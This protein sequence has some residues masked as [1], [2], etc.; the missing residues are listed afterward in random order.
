MVAVSSGSREIVAATAVA[1]IM[2]I[3]LSCGAVYGL[4]RYLGPIEE[5]LQTTGSVRR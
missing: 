1:L 5:P 3:L 2:G 4:N